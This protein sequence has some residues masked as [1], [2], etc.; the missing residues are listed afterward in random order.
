MFGMISKIFQMNHQN[1]WL[2]TEVISVR[3][4]LIGL[5]EPEIKAMA[6]TTKLPMII[7]W[8]VFSSDQ[9]TNTIWQ[10]TSSI[11]RPPAL[12]IDVVS[13]TIEPLATIV[14]AMSPTI[15]PLEPV[16]RAESPTTSTNYEAVTNHQTINTGLRAKSSNIG[17]SVLVVEWSHQTPN[18]RHWSRNGGTSHKRGI[19]GH[20]IGDLV[21]RWVG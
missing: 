19:S 8:A 10:K 5:L 18:R 12:V 13:S 6:P 17:S 21:T 16:T 15:E 4:S 20:W 2:N 14:D 9:T 3:D 1:W 11:T 7:V